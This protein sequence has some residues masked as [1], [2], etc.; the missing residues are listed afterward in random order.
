MNARSLQQ[1]FLTLRSNKSFEV[2]VIVI[3]IFSALVIGA[4][5]YDLPRSVLLAVAVL[6][7]LITAIFLFEICVRFVA[8]ENKRRFFLQG[9][10][11]FDTLIVVISLFP[12]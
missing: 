8:E 1:K 3:I 12:F 4:K 7:W 11:I 2:F 10:N 9:W 6:D 5:T